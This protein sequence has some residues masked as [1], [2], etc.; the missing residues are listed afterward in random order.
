MKCLILYIVGLYS[1]GESV[2][3]WLKFDNLFI[4]GTQLFKFYQTFLL[5]TI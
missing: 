5:C 2:V 1:I 3:D 4:G